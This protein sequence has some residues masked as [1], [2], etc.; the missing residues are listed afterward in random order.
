MALEPIT[1][2]QVEVFGYRGPVYLSMIRL[3]SK[4]CTI[5][6]DDGMLKI[7]SN[8]KVACIVGPTFWK[9]VCLVRK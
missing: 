4:T 7:T 3:D 1:L 9:C 6:N 5:V 8:G 2:E